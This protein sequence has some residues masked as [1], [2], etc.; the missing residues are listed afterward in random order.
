LYDYVFEPFNWN[1][2]EEAIQ[3]GRFQSKHIKEALNYVYIMYI[4]YL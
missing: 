1:N 2:F 4:Y 3:S